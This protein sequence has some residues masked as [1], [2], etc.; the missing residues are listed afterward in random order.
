MQSYC[1]QHPDMS[2]RDAMLALF[3]EDALALRR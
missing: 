2:L 3:E 1:A